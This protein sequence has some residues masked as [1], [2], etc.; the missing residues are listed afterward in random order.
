[1]FDE[2][3]KNA[4]SSLAYNYQ[5]EPWFVCVGITGDKESNPEL[6]IYCD[7]VIPKSIIL[8]DTWEGLPV[9]SERIGKIYPV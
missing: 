1:M 3:T 8:V 9:Q 7:A 2:Q 5:N 6:I 4:A